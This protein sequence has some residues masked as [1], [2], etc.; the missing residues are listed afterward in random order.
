MNDVAMRAYRIQL[1]FFGDEVGVRRGGVC[2]QPIL[3]FESSTENVHCK[4]ISI[5]RM[6]EQFFQVNGSVNPQVL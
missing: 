5:Q 1:F 4:N 2:G 3:L 6:L